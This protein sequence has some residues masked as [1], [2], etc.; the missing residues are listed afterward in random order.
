VARDDDLK[1]SVKGVDID[2]TS[3]V[4]FQG[5]L[6]SELYVTVQRLISGVETRVTIAGPRRKP[7]LRLASTPPLEPSDILSFEIEAPDD[8]SRS[9]PRI[10]IGDE[11][12]PGL[13]ARF[14][15]QFGRDE[16]DEATIEY[17]LSR[18]LRIRATFSD[19]ASLNARS[20]FRR[21]ERAGID[22]IQNLIQLQS[23]NIGKVLAIERP[24]L[25]AVHDRG[26]GDRHIH[27]ALPCALQRSV[28]L[29][30]GTGFG[31]AE[32]N[33]ARRGQ[34]RL[35]RGKLPRPAWTPQP[36]VQYE[37]RARDPFPVRE[38]RPQGV[39][40]TLRTGHRIDQGRRIEVN[41]RCRRGD[42]RPGRHPTRRLS[43]I[44]LSSRSTAAAD[45]LPRARGR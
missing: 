9:G 30:R 21:T 22:L 29:S 37:G 42:G 25:R 31:D 19:A 43:R 17:Y 28:Q 14:S 45:R 40:A 34:Q 8:P 3:S 24:Q 20:P 5:D 12:F 11:L 6:N 18:I 35:L 15:R 38:S 4:N 32:W 2:P 33:S 26:G 13:V 7:E 27:L 1:G 41:H 10:T 44:S 16:Y 23:G 36:F 39:Y